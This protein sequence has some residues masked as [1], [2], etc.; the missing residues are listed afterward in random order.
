MSLL[1]TY[2]SC[3]ELIASNLNEQ[4]VEASAEEGLTTLA[5]KILLINNCNKKSKSKLIIRYTI[6]I[7]EELENEVNL[8]LFHFH[9]IGPTT[10]LQI[11]KET[12]RNKE[13]IK[14]NIPNGRYGVYCNIL[15]Y[16]D[17]PL[18]SN[19]VLFTHGI[20]TDNNDL[21]LTIHIKY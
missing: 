14:E 9:L 13:Y 11:S 8:G 6:D 5:N 12:F 18:K 10:S 7:P 19:S 15:S 20:L 2:N 3:K 17:P 1:E 21:I 4:E 16:N